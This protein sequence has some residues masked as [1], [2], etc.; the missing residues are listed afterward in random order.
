MH[1]YV[2]M[3]SWCMRRQKPCVWQIAANVRYTVCHMKRSEPEGWYAHSMLAAWTSILGLTLK[4]YC[5]RA[6]AHRATAWTHRILDV[7]VGVMVPAMEQLCAPSL[8]TT[9]PTKPEQGTLPTSGLKLFL[10]ATG[11]QGVDSAMPSGTV[12]APP[13]HPARQG[14]RRLER[15]EG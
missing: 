12:F 3:A 6:I 13:M 11:Q 15:V 1:T 2:S 14:R 10:W 9:L 8:A 4:I 7:M 5:K